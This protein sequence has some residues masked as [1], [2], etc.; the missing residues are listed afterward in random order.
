M[1]RANITETNLQF[2]ALMNRSYT[3]MIVIHHTGGKDIDASAEQIHEWHINADYSGIGYHFVVRKDGTIE[4]GR[5]VDTIGAHAFGENYHSIGIH[6][7]GDFDKTIP[8]MA[9]IEMTS[10][11]TANLCADFGI[12][13]DKKHIVGHCDLMATDCPGRNLYEKIAIIVGKAN[14][15]RWN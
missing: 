7:S 3:D 8:T 10:M 6:L 2:G 12:P 15:Y 5:P 11:L 1:Q 13:I 14:W 4:R 9:Q